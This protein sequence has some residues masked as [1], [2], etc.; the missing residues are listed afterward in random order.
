MRPVL[1]IKIIVTDMDDKNQ[2]FKVSSFVI[3]PC[4]PHP[5]LVDYNYIKLCRITFRVI[6]VYFGSI[7]QLIKPVSQYDSFYF[8]QHTMWRLKPR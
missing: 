5:G 8:K 4:R 6:Y 7:L 1:N 3:E 2:N